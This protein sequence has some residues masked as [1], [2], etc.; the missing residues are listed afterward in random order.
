MELNMVDMNNFNLENSHFFSHSSIFK[1]M[2]GEQIK[3]DQDPMPFGL[4]LQESFD[5]QTNLNEQKGIPSHG[6][7]PTNCYTGS[8]SCLDLDVQF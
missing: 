5:K 6:P 1:K 7:S 4:S 8:D 2:T 3:S